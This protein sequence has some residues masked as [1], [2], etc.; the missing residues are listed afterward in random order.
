[1]INDQILDPKKHIASRIINISVKYNSQI[2]YFI[3][4]IILICILIYDH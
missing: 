3:S 1:M 2:S 4:W